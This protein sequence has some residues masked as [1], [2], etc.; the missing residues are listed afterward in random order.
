M[1]DL[2]CQIEVKPAFY[3]V[4]P[5][6][7]GWHGHYVKYFELA[8]AELLGR[9]GYGY[10]AM[11]DSGYVWPIVELHVKYVKSAQLEQPLTVKATITEYEQRLRVDYLITNREGVRLTRGHTVQVAV[12]SK[13]KELQYVCP[14]VLWDKLGVS[15]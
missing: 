8:R 2:S 14:K 11:L 9:F 1:P 4:D 10:Q 15:P 3:D 12:D 6:F 13:S 5:M 7:I